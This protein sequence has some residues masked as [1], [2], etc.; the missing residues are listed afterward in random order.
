V[1]TYPISDNAL[2]IVAVQ[3][4]EDWA[5]DG[6]HHA[7]D[8]ANLRGAFSDVGSDL[9]FIL[10]GVEQTHL[11]G[12]FRYPVATTWHSGRVVILGD[13]AHPTLPFLAQGANLA[14]EDAYV[15]AACCDTDIP[16]GLVQYQAERKPRVTRAIAAANA[17]A[18]NYHLSGLRRTIAHRGLKTL[19]FLAPGA[20]LNRM[21][22]L[23]G[24]DVTQ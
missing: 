19:G 12:L 18:R 6:W 13:A 11:W 8:P 15:L 14:I 23:Y 10:D 17:N 5:E 4:R 3:E 21:D 1:V 7:D 16:K 20:F 22:W 24:L 2:N 9:A